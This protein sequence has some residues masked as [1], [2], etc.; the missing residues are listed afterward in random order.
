MLKRSLAGGV[1]LVLFLAG[2]EPNNQ[3]YAPEQ[4]IKY[5]HAVHA[6]AMEVPCQYCHFAAER[7]RHAGIPPAE[8]CM[9]CHVQVLPDHP[10]VVKVKQAIA[11]GEAIRWVRV[12]KVPDHVYFNHSAHVNGGV[13]CVTCHGDVAGMGRVEQ[14]APLTMGWCVGCHRDNT[15]L[16]AGADPRLAQAGPL[17]DCTVCHH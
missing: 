6:G 13:E 9:N 1:V 4:P 10:E 7:G 11:T 8:V 3:G 14:F 16:P 2:C 5:S 17:V 12:H 15:E